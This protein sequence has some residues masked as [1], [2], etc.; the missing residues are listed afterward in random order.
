MFRCSFF[1]CVKVGVSCT[2]SH[3]SVAV[4]LICLDLLAVWEQ[5]LQFLGLLGYY[6]GSYKWYIPWEKRIIISINP[7]QQHDPHPPSRQSPLFHCMHKA[8]WPHTSGASPVSTSPLTVGV[9]GCDVLGDTQLYTGTAVGVVTLQVFYPL[10]L[11]PAHT[12]LFIRA[13]E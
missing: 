11:L 3:S 4:G 6:L 5:F 2:F 8:W 7:Y 13:K 12:V 1:F 10:S 9:W